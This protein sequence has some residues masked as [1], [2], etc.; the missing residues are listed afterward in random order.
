MLTVFIN[1]VR[2]YFIDSQY[3]SKRFYI[4]N[5][6]YLMFDCRTNSLPTD[7]ITF[8]YKCLEDWSFIWIDWNN[9]RL[10]QKIVDFLNLFCV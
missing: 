3:V 7:N 1:A 10:K 8:P 5:D 4:D 2:Y 6:W 9:T